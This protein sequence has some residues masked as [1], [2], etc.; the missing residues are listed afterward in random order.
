MYK[1][2]SFV[3]GIWSYKI[4]MNL[5]IFYKVKVRNDVERIYNCIKIMKRIIFYRMEIVKR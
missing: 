1:V 2:F 5:K 3:F 4:N